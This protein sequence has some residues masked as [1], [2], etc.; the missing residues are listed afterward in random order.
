M[1]NS[2]M[3]TGS[4]NGARSWIGAGVFGLILLFFM[5]AMVLGKQLG[6][7]PKIV[8]LAGHKSHGPGA[9][10]YEKDLRLLQS[11]LDDSKNVGPLRTELHL[12]GWPEDPRTLDDADCIVLFSDGADQNEASHPL[13][14][15]ERLKVIERQMDRGCGLVIQHYATILPRRV[16][17]QFLQW[18]GGYFDYES[19]PP[20]GKWYSKIQWAT[21]VPE[22]AS[23]N[24]PIVRGIRP[25]R[26]KEEYYYRMRFAEETKGWTSILKTAIPEEKQPQVVA[27]AMQRPDGGRGFA[28]TCGHTHANFQLLDFRK[29]HLNAIVWCAGMDVPPGG[30]ESS[31]PAAWEFAEEPPTLDRAHETALKNSLRALI[32]TGDE[33]P[34][35]KWQE[36]SLAL[37][38]IL[39]RDARFLVDVTHD[40]EYLARC[41][42]KDMDYDVIVW[43][44][45]N[46]VNPGMSEKAQEAFLAYMKDG[47]G[48]C[49]VHFAD[50][51]FHF[52]LP[53]AP[54]SDW[55]AWRQLCRRV[56][57]HKGASGH[58]AY[59]PFRVEI[60]D[61]EH[62]ITRDMEAFETRDELYFRQE[63]QL[64][65]K[66]LATARSR[67]TG[68]DEPMAWVNP[69]GQGRVFQT[70]LGH[71][72][73][74][75]RNEGASELILR[76]C[77]WA[78][79][80][81]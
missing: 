66:V 38:E 10:E 59:G 35:H 17:S 33:H 46:W 49:L 64:P 7:G 32:V 41:S 81:R 28:T 14:V 27:W 42:L 57:N 9:H 5:P 56:W 20:A 50:G 37:R 45:C 53:E 3:T 76:G 51:A 67:T 69:D 74:S 11:C 34:A 47:G 39:W 71:S 2:L 61:S 78:A 30:V 63:G 23:P 22:L 1:R 54:P 6:R 79:G 16:E 43:N 72:V 80:A 13:L 25:F 40:P 70:L 62:S 18:V 52:S 48:L 68:K 65:I 55:P 26:L 12:E 44:Y 8:F 36:T 4:E 77:L 60:S 75:V 31:V 21:T 29:L 58:D 24:H 73:E 19:G 15:G